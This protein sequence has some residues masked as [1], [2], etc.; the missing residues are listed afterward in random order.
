MEGIVIKGIAG[1]HGL[2][3]GI[4]YLSLHGE[5]ELSVDQRATTL[6]HESAHN[7]PSIGDLGYFGEQCAKSAETAALSMGELFINADSYACLAYLLS[8]ETEE[9]LRSRVEYHK[10]EYRGETLEGIVQDPP[11]AIDLNSENEHLPR[12][13]IKFE[14]EEGYPPR[15]QNSWRRQ[16]VGLLL[17]T[18]DLF[19]LLAC[20]VKR[21]R[22]QI[23]RPPLPP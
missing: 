9:D 15:N 1:Y 14:G 23:S 11:G 6:I 10:R 19:L 16:S 13:Y 5:G 20:R 8:H 3:R 12:Y 21:A 7:L 17:R 4:E 18:P 22:I 2:G